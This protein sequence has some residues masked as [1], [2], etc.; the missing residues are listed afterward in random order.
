MAVSMGVGSVACAGSEPDGE[1]VM[2]PPVVSAAPDSG[3]FS[4]PRDISE[5]TDPDDAEPTDRIA[6]SESTN[7]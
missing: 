1:S 5:T 6:V 2:M 7:D 4:D 3:W